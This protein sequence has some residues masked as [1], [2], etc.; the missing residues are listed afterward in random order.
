M[1]GEI[2]A[3]LKEAIEQKYR[4][5]ND[6]FNSFLRDVKRYTGSYDY[7]TGG[8]VNTEYNG[9]PIRVDYFYYD[10]PF[11]GG[12]YNVV[13]NVLTPMDSLAGDSIQAALDNAF[14]KNSKTQLSNKEIKDKILEVISTL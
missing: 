1:Y 5:S 12:G 7:I 10:R 9:Q 3:N 13:I 4:K 6:R 14:E 2:R 8:K 11:V